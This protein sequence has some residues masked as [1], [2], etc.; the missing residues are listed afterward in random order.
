MNKIYEDVSAFLK[1]H[2][3]N[4]RSC[5]SENKAGYSTTYKEETN[6]AEK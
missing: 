6:K 1:K 3:L 2:E 5:S 4:I